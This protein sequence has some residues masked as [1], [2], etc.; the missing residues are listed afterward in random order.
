LAFPVSD[1]L[2]DRDKDRGNNPYEEM[3]LAEP[4]ERLADKQLLRLHN[5]I[6]ERQVETSTRIFFSP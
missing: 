2:D 5:G 4:D 6:E 3:S 1:Q